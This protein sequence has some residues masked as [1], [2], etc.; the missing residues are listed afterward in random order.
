MARYEFPTTA[1]LL[2]LGAPRE[3]AV[4][5]Y[6]PATAAEFELAR[7]TVKSSFDE[8]IRIL[9]RGHGTDELTQVEVLADLQLALQVV[10]QDEYLNG[11]RRG[12]DRERP[13]QLV[14]ALVCHNLRDPLVEGRLERMVRA[15]LALGKSLRMQITAEGVEHER[16]AHWLA[17]N[18]CDFAQGY[19]FGR[20]L[21]PGRVM[22]VLACQQALQEHSPLRAG[23]LG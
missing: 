18:G 21:P 22:D 5:V 10:R 6:A 23:G 1:E 12:E 20:P 8:A 11:L 9:R 4:T 19:L 3:N 13:R 17:D 15:I 2:E 7:T 16:L 14:P